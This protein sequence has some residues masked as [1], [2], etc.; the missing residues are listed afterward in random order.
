MKELRKYERVRFLC[1]LE[2]AAIP[3][4]EPRPASSVDLSLGGV[5]VVT[6]ATFSVGQLVTVTFFLADS[7]SAGIQDPVVGR[8]AHFSA[9]V[10]SNRVGIQFLQPLKEKEHER[11]VGRLIVA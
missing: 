7:T 10:N 9:D 8:V 1:R 6:Q 3:D 11:L 4:G 5:G 2:V